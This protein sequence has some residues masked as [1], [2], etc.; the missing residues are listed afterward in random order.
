MLQCQTVSTATM[1]T[2]RPQTARPQTA[3]RM[4]LLSSSEDALHALDAVKDET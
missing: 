1:Q 3:R 2:K 4:V